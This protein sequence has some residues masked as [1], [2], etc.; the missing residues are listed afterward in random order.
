MEYVI[1][2][3]RETRTVLIDGYNSGLTNETL[4]INDGLHTFSLK[5]PADFSPY[6]HTVEVEDTTG[7]KPME[8][9]FA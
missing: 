8:V 7:I 9:F 3:F 2:R 4:M 6:E 5:G 1:V